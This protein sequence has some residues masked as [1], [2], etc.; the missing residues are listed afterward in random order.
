MHI[1]LPKPITAPH[2]RLG[3]VF[4]FLFLLVNLILPL[5][6]LIS[7]ENPVPWQVGGVLSVA[8]MGQFRGAW[9][10]KQVL[11]RRTRG[12]KILKKVL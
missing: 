11:P 3:L 6:T 5:G 12:F 10:K 4:D 8:L 7:F 2:K 1:S 9:I